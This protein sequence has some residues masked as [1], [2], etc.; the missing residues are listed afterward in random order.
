M[1]G[2]RSIFANQCHGYLYPFLPADEFFDREHFPWLAELEAATPTIR[3]ELAAILAGDDPGLR[4][5]STMD[6]GTPRNTWTELDHSFDWSA[7]H[8]WREGE[9]IDE[10]C[11]RAPRTAALVERC[12][13]RAF[14]G[15]RRRSSSRCSRPA[16]TSRRTPG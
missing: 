1:L 14:P 10:A 16:R 12:R 5:M 9:R 3:E 4:P 8:L 15:A 2:R 11:A 6:P 7:L 13:W